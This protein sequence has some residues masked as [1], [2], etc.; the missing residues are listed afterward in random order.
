MK[1]KLLLLALMM[2]SFLFAEEVEE[3]ELLHRSIPIE[4]IYTLSPDKPYYEKDDV[5][6]ISATFTYLRNHRNFVESEIVKIKIEQPARND[7]N[8]VAEVDSF[9]LT[10]SNNVV[11]KNWK[12]VFNKSSK[13]GHLTEI[14][15]YLTTRS[16][17]N[18]IYLKQPEGEKSPWI[19]SVDYYPY[20][21]FII[22]KLT[23]SPK[24]IPRKEKQTNWK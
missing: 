19:N 22:N 5:V 6:N 20:K 23:P 11:T 14:T 12:V 16:Y 8:V 9:D 4:V 10:A 18:Q 1:K 15:T 13:A 2:Y 3:V 21:Y 7:F 24:K 17:Y